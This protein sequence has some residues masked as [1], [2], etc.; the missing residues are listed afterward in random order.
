MQNKRTS[1]IVFEKIEEKILSGEWEPGCKIMSE[2]QLAKELG[3][4]RMS[5]R[6]AMEKMSALNIITKKQ[7]EGTFVNSLS[8]AIYLNS[9]IPMIMLDKDNYLDILEYRLITEVESA[10]LCASKCSEEIIKDLE[11]CYEIMEAHQEDYEK[12][13]EADMRFHYKIAEGSG[14]SLLFKVN[15]VLG[16]VLQ[17]HQRALYKHLGPTGGIKEHKILLEAIKNRDAELSAIFMKRHLER[18]IRDIKN[19]YIKNL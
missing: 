11:E 4:S 17:Y 1:E 13:S 6:E 16:S 14:N 10:R 8:P 9:L 18:T 12:F 2:P 7:G 19:K 3:V 15:N 5:V